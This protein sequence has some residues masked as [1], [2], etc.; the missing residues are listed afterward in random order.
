MV[1][2]LVSL[3]KKKGRPMDAL[4]VVVMTVRYGEVF[5]FDFP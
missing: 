4:M 2:V 1:M 5:R 3:F